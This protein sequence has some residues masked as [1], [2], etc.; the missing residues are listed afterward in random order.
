MLQKILI[1]E[2]SPD[3]HEIYAEAL[4]GK[5][6]IISALSI[7]Q[8]QKLFDGNQ[9]IKLIVMDYS[10]P[11]REDDKYCSNTIDLIKY[12]KVRFSGPIIASSST[13]DCRKEQLATGCT[14][15]C[16]KVQVPKKIMEL[17]G[18]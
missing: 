17:L 1:V 13:E 3:L 18:I 2:D 10:V 9:D 15:E 12:I 7:E 4:K 11:F 5:I 16:G 6:E 8:A 14:H